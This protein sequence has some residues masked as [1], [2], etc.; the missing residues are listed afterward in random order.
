MVGAEALIRWLHPERGLLPPEE[1]LPALGKFIDQMTGYFRYSTTD[2]VTCN[3]T[4]G[5]R[6]PGSGGTA[7]GSSYSSQSFSQSISGLSAGT[8]YYYCAIAQNSVGTSFGAVVSFAER[9][10][11]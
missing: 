11:L 10:L 9:G 8:T 5:S 1:F 2:P 6:A 4:F 3:D 7:L